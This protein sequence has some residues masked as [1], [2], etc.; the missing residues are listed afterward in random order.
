MVCTS[1]IRFS[2]TAFAFSLS[3]FGLEGAVLWE[4]LWEKPSGEELKPATKLHGRASKWSFSLSC[5]FL[6]SRFSC[7]RLS[8]TPWT[9]AHQAPLPK[10]CPRQEHWSGL[11]LPSLG[12]LPKPGIKYTSPALAN[13]FFTT[14]P[15]GKP[16]APE[17]RT[18][19]SVTL[20][21]TLSATLWKIL[22][23]TQPAKTFQD[24]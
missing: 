3:S 20:P 16:S 17:V 10:G 24:F 18:S 22:S 21:N 4:A 14:E 2:K 7:V 23:Q 11:P 1:K 15:P 12:D 8:V 5:L 19:R 13:R 9:V 6:V